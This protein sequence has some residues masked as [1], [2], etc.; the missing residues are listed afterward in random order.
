[1]LEREFIAWRERA[2]PSYAKEKVLSGQWAAAESL[3]LSKQAHDELLP[4]GL[5]TP[6]NHFHTITDEELTAVGT[7]WFAVKLSGDTRLAYV[8]DVHIYPEHQRKGHAFRA[9]RWL[10]QRA[11]ELDL[12]GVALHVFGH[13]VA[14]QALYSKLGF[15]PTNINLIKHVNPR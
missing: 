15:K 8:F 3:A 12:S 6:D 2:I 7:L 10:E 5:A 13:N 4:Q 9:F 14:A 1:M 11:L